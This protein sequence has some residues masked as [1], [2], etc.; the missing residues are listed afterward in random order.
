[1]KKVVR[2]ELVDWMTYVERRDAIRA[3][4]LAA[5]EA[6]R[7][8]VGD[9]LTFL[10]E[11]QTTIRYQIQEMMRVERLVREADIQHELDTYNALIGG[12]GEL[13]CTLLVE[14][15][16]EK[17]RDLKLRE[18][19]T[20]PEHVYVRLASG[21]KVRAG[22]DEEQRSRGR[23]STVQYLK[24]EVGSNVPVAVGCDHPALTC[25]TALSAARIA[26][27]RADLAS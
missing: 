13:G 6:R 11:N 20:L 19:L 27:M 12:T 4:A 17:E 21:A 10:F 7:V 14:I 22:V 15:E 9:Y 18:W 2:S 25:E 1:M 16:D 23:L 8:H 26:A 24:F 5:K 3:E